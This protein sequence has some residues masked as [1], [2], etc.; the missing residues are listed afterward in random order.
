MGNPPLVTLIDIAAIRRT[1]ELSLGI[2]AFIG[3][4]FNANRLPFYA[5]S[6]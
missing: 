3:F 4:S 6:P 5:I 1:T 2:S